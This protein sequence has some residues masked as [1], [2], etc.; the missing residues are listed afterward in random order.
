MRPRKGL[1][2]GCSCVT[3]LAVVFLTA[4]CGADTVY[5]GLMVT[6]VDIRTSGPLLTEV[7]MLVTD[8]AFADTVR[9]APPR[10]LP[11]ASAYGRPGTYLIELTAVGYRTWRMSGVRVGRSAICE[12]IDTR[13]ITA[14]LEAVGAT[15]E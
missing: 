5:A 11:L 8:G 14:R 4:C 6:V 1:G 9:A 10:T 12:T 3:A 13:H 15:S 2:R 7:T